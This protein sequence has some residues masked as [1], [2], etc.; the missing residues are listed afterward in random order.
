MKNGPAQ[1]ADPENVTLM[2]E[3][4]ADLVQKLRSPGENKEEIAQQL[5]GYLQ[6]NITQGDLG[7]DALEQWSGKLENSTGGELAEI[8]EN[9]SIPQEFQLDEGGIFEL[10]KGV[11]AD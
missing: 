8:F 11:L 2:V 10:I 6:E 5:A 3:S 4:I 1:A 7:Y 9:L